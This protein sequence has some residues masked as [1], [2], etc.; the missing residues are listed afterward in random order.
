MRPLITLLLMAVIGLSQA[1]NGYQITDTTKQ[2]NTVFG[3]VITY[4][5]HQATNTSIHK[6]GSTTTINEETYFTLLESTDSL[7]NEWSE[8]GYIRE[9]TIE[10]KIYY[11]TADEGDGLIYDYSLAEGETVTINNHYMGISDYEMICDSID[12]INIDGSLKKRL[13]LIGTYSKSDYHDIWIQGVGSVRG[14]LCSGRTLP[15]GYNELLCCKK[16]STT[17]YDNED[18]HSCFVNEFHP[19]IATESYDTAYI[20]TYYEFQMEYTNNPYDDPVSWEPINLPEGLEINQNTGLVSGIPTE[21]GA[22]TCTI[23]IR[24]NLLGFRTDFINKDLFVVNSTDI[25]ESQRE[26]KVKIYPNPADERIYIEMQNYEEAFYVSVYDPS[27]RMIQQTEIIQNPA[28]IDCSEFSSGIYFVKV[29]S[30]D[31]RVVA[32]RKIAVR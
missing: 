13:F 4:S 20:N 5:V 28:K 26:L 7:E 25:P 10:Q 30:S 12:Y 3:G 8:A 32:N 31:N 24:N 14:L 21:P 19:D 29:M 6:M 17:L 27:G 11:Y 23:A 9:D 1:Q 18:Y 15:G 22:Q 16:N 2:W